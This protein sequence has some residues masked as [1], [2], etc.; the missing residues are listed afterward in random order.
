[1]SSYPQN[2]I[3][4]TAKMETP[5][6][7]DRPKGRRV[8][9]WDIL[10]LRGKISMKFMNTVAIAALCLQAPVAYAG[11]LAPTVDTTDVIVVPADPKSS[12]ADYVIPLIFLG[13]LVAASNGD[14]AGGSNGGDGGGLEDASDSRLKEDIVQ[15]GVAHNGLPLYHFSYLGSDVRYEGVM[16][17]DVLSYM[18]QAVVRMSN[19][20]LGVRYDMLG[21]QMS[22]VD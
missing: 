12:A 19:G 11:G 14:S 4:H 17:Q 10:L 7:L 21:L 18:P 20:Y 15:V 16:A 8:R 22:V 1:M 13:L 3:A 5:T 6:K 9:F 2:F